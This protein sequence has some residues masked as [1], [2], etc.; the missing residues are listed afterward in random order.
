MEKILLGV[1]L[2]GILLNKIIP[3]EYF[4]LETIPLAISGLSSAGL[5]I[6]R[7]YKEVTEYP[8]I[9]DLDLY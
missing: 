3:S 4:R 9:E 1:T 2:G 5:L 7:T 8:K 6:V